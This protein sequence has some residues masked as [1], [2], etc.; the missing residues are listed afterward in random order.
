MKLHKYCSMIPPM[1]KDEFSTL[2][3]SISRDGLLVPIVMLGDEILDGR[4]RYQACKDL[5]IEPI[6]EQ[7]AGDNP[8]NYAISLNATRRHLSQSQRAMLASSIAT[9]KRGGV[10]I[11][12]NT[13]ASQ[14]ANLPL[15]VTQ[16]QAA[17]ELNVSER[18]VK[19][20]SYIGKTAPS[21][22]TE[23]VES[24]AITLN[25]ATKLI[26]NT[27]P[28]LLARSTPVEL[29]SMAKRLSTNV[30]TKLEKTVS[31]AK[32]L[33]EEYDSLRQYE[34]TEQVIAAFHDVHFELGLIAQMKSNIKPPSPSEPSQSA[35]GSIDTV[36]PSK[37]KDDLTGLKT[38]DVIRLYH[39]ST[40]DIA[41][42]FSAAYKQSSGINTLDAKN[43]EHM[44][45]LAE[46]MVGL[47]DEQ[48]NNIEADKRA[49]IKAKRKAKKQ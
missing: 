35:K 6:T 16:K 17:K 34:Q 4:H 8:F 41:S 18:M 12:Q 13:T 9:L 40:N 45:G 2:K 32:Q 39:Q 36:I 33:R 25:A 27:E 28:E 49:A 21:I 46:F 20:A 24:G 14:S 31:L 3:D 30:D 15:E 47:T 29:E 48:C 38:N 23:S 37:A 22:I 26:K 5:G 43:P 19:T 44:Q 1:S 7:Y 10:R 11:G 42:A